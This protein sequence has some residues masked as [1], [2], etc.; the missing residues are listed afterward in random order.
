MSNQLKK[1]LNF[2]SILKSNAEVMKFG[3]HVALKMPWAQAL[4]GSSPSLGTT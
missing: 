2:D 3:K 4:E 1:N